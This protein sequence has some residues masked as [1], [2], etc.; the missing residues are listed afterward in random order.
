MTLFTRYR[1]LVMVRRLALVMVAVGLFSVGIAA[2]QPA[3]SLS[4]RQLT[5][6]D[7]LPA[8]SVH[9]VLEDNQGFMWFGTRDGL[10]RY[11]GRGMRVFRPEVGDPQS[12]GDRRVNDLKE[13][14]QSNLWVATDNGLDFWDR[15]TERFVHFRANPT[16]PASLSHNTCW[17]V[18]PNPDGSIWVGTARGL[19]RFDSRAGT[20]EQFLPDRVVR[21]LLRDR[22]GML[23]IGTQS[24][25][26]IQFDPQTGHFQP[27]PADANQQP[28]LSN[29]LI[30]SLA[31]DGEGNL[32]IGTHGGLFRLD[33]KRHIFER[34]GSEAHNS[35][36]LP[37][38][39]VDAVLVDR[40]GG[41]WVGMDGGGLSRFDPSTRR[42]VHHRHSR[43][44]TNTLTS[45]M[46][47]SLYEDRQ[48]DLWVGHFPAGI[49]HANQLAAPFQVFRALPGDTNSLSDENAA[50][51]WEDPSGDLWVGTDNGGLNHWE[52][53]TGRWK[54]YQHDPRNPGSLP[55]NSVLSVMRDRRGALWVGTW[56]GG[57]NRF[58][59]A[60]GTFR[61]YLPDATRA[62][63]LSNPHAWRLHEDRQGQLWVATAGGGI[64]RYVPE[65]DA[66]VHH[67]HNPAD[68][69]SL[70][71]DY[72]WS[73]MEDRAGQL[74][75]GTAVGLTRR[76]PTTGRWQ[77]WPD[78]TGSVEALSRYPITDLL[79][80]REGAIWAC[81]HGAGL[82]RLD[83]RTGKVDGLRVAE[84]LPSEVTRGILEDDDGILWVSTN[85]GLARVDPRTRQVRTVDDHGGLPSRF[86]L[87]HARHRLRSGELVFGTTQGFVKFQPR[88]IQ[89]N[90]NPPPVVLTDLEIFNQRV[91]P[92]APESPLSQ[93]LAKTRRLEIPARLSMLT[94]HFAVLNYRSPQLNRCLYQLEGF[95]KEWRVSSS[96]FRAIY[97]NLD[98]GRY[99]LRVKAANNDGV[100]N[101]TGAS[102]E[103]IIVPP[104]WRT[105][106]FRAVAV[107]LILG[108]AVRGGATIST[109]RTRARI[110]EMEKER[111]LAREREQ[112]AE[113]VRE[114]RQMLRIILD[115]IPVRVFWKDAALVYLGCNQP[116]ARDAGLA[117]VAD[118]V[119]KDDFGMAWGVE[120]GNLYRADDQQVM[121]SGEPKIGYEESQTRFDGRLSWVR[122]SKVPLRDLDGRVVGILG[123]YED[124]TEFKQAQTESEKLQNQLTQAQKIESIGR[125]AG[126]I[127]HV[128]QDPVGPR[129]A[130]NSAWSEGVVL[131]ARY[132]CT[133]PEAS[134]AASRSTSSTLTRL[135]SPGMLCFKALAATAKRRLS[136]AER[137]VTNP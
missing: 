5:I 103:L 10:V 66:F 41:V 18:L 28:S 76:D 30:T 70:L 14:A 62:K 74:W 68:P 25:G 85:N 77:H 27:F 93:S 132:L 106:W 54:V 33:A 4:F 46:V 107:L 71:N 63:A 16:D 73:L 108:S 31:E 24:G 78:T 102:L 37:T 98:P 121:A 48:G 44:A 56:N 52:A 112:A 13:D 69:S 23:W 57:L 118:V 72:V 86:F 111:Q 20:W 1:D 116:F 17:T 7:G 122:T 75:A 124:I 67:R 55:S 134:P 136:A 80:D 101:E 128:R 12:M 42:F 100:W 94:F 21:C 126:G 39:L 130:E 125:L 50:A 79:E 131:S 60:T 91:V 38:Q 99:R 11:D 19:N 45:D 47:R 115:T 49:S 8:A 34:Y 2:A 105:W 84:G 29:G 9:R 117:S 59:P 22:K 64:D 127:A 15:A 58:E 35:S 113:I 32:W 51:F 110:I 129:H 40:T 65:E 43:Y 81:T 95:D 90:T 87:T 6:Q 36:G 133:R 97:N 88:A 82:W 109:R 104:W 53:A 61:H 3:P 114:S 92:G 89:P 123:S 135:K 137:P 83:P 120:Q 119:G 96:D 26:L